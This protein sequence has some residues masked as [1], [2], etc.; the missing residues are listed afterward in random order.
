MESTNLTDTA[1]AQEPPELEKLLHRIVSERWPEIA[2]FALQR[3][4]DGYNRGYVRVT[5]RAGEL[6]YVQVPERPL[7]MT[8]TER[9][10]TL[11]EA[12]LSRE[13]C[14]DFI[15]V[16]LEQNGSLIWRLFSS[17]NEQPMR[18]AASSFDREQK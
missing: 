10:W 6:K 13:N 1:T 15:V 12:V 16:A 9:P 11:E 14:E 4:G 2:D 3:C 8:A 18:E 17:V 7:T 5:D